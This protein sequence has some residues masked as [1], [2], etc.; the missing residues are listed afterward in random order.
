MFT[1]RQRHG[2]EA[3]PADLS[4]STVEAHRTVDLSGQAGWSATHDRHVR[5]D[6]RPL[7]HH[8]HR[9]RLADAAA[10]VSPLASRLRVLFLLV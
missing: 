5:G 8:S 4:E 2:K 6:E 9:L 7:L 3:I 10:R 1:L